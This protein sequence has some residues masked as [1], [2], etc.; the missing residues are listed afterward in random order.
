M[1]IIPLKFVPAA[2][3]GGLGHAGVRWRS[4]MGPAIAARSRIVESGVLQSPPAWVPPRFW[5]RGGGMGMA[6]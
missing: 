1:S 3:L 4:R 2:R 6:S 5:A